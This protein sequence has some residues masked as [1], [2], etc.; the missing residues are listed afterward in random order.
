MST[1]TEVPTETPTVGA[2]LSN[3]R[4]LTDCRVLLPL[5][6]LWLVLVIVEINYIFPLIADAG[7]PLSRIAFGEFYSGSFATTLGKINQI[8][9]TVNAPI[10]LLVASVLMWRTRNEL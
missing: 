8:L 9:I 1:E 2:T 4:P 3:L 6:V 10:C 7:F 5:R